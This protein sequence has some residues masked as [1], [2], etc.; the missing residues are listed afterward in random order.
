MADK[1]LTLRVEQLQAA[2][3]SPR[4]Q[5]A[6]ATGCKCYRA[7]CRKYCITPSPTTQLTLCY[8]AAYLSR[9]VQYPTVR[10][11]IAAVRSQQLSKGMEDPLKEPQQLNLIMKGLNKQAKTHTR[12]PISPPLLRTLVHT[13]LR[14][15][16]MEKHDRHLYATAI[17]L[18]YF[19]CLRAGELSYPSTHSYHHKQHLTMRDISIHNNA[20]HLWLKQS[21]TDQACKG[22]TIIIGPGNA[23]ICPVHTTKQFLHFRRHARA[24]DALFR[25]QDGSLLTRPRLQ[26][27]LRKALRSLKL[28]AELFGTHSLRLGSATAAAEVG[29]PMDI[30][31]AMGRWSS[32]CYRNYMRTPHKTLRSLTSKLCTSSQ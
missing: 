21:K 9:Q 10:L 8:F 26:T 24:S 1:A 22:A 28:P 17:C 29:I 14:M 12:L 20:V 6:Y 3:L 30:I 25:F 4:T 16:H 2:A 7:F 23:D 18:A 5:Q 13:V 27:L 32:D 11:Y 31:K 15:R 19:G